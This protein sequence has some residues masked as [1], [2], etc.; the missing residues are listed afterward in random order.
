[1]TPEQDQL[2]QEW[3]RDMHPRLAR[4]E[5]FLTP[6]E[7]P[8]GFTRES[9]AGLEQLMLDR[10]PS[11][12][13]FAQE[14]DTD[15]MDGATRY[16]GETYLRLGGGGWSVDHDP[17]HVFSGRPMVRLDTLDRT[18]ISPLHLMTSL[19]TRRTGAVLTKVWDGQA[20]NVEERRA[21]EGEG[22][23]PQ[24]EPV[25]GI[26]TGRRPGSPELDAWTGSVARRVAWLRSRPGGAVLDGSPASLPDLEQIVRADAAAGNLGPSGDAE[27]LL[28]FEA[29]LG[30]VALGA[31]GGEWV[32]VPGS[33]G[34]ANPFVGR[35][36]VERLVEGGTPRTMLVGLLLDRV[37]TSDAVGL[38][39][40]H[41]GG[42][43]K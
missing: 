43:A 26:R 30:E 38:L 32:L 24:R 9:L 4:F 33:P 29:Y 25:P 19:L 23:Q 22:W 1:M 20:E 11:A 34:G 8:G 27:L 3:L 28:A 39:A 16:I 10:W 41:V 37:A 14:Q 7:W 36:F 18:P 2:F 35:P 12:D 21:A 17:R 40:R 42:Y 31:A 6:R 5:D 15:F 13:A